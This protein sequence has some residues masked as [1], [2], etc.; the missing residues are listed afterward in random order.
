MDF[1]FSTSPHPGAECLEP[2][3]EGKFRFA[4]HP[5]VPCFTNCCADLYLT[6]TPYDV[7]RLKSALRIPS[8]E[9]LERYTADD[10]CQNSGLPVVVLKMKE[11]PKKKCPFLFPAGCSVYTDRPGACRLYPVGRAARYAGRALQ[12]EYF[13]VKESHCLGFAE[14]REW[15]VQD[16]LVDQGLEAYNEMN[17]LW[18]GINRNVASGQSLPPVTGDKLKMYFM[19]CYNLDQFQRF[20]F[21]SPLLRMFRIDKDT[22][23]RIRADQIELLKFAFTWVEFSVFGKKTMQIRPSVLKAKARAHHRR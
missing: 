11:D 14:E 22:L 12:E 2:F 20:V 9:F 1:T 17:A 15:T 4:C 21:E 18:M 5:G 13:L 23:T 3:T 10:L 6:L 8:A 16:W 19:A 7:L